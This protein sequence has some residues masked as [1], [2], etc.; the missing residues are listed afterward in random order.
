MTSLDA[1]VLY[2]MLVVTEETAVRQSIKYNNYIL[3]SAITID[4]SHT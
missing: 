2:N 3:S 1:M 4:S